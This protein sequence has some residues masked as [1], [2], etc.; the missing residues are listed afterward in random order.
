MLGWLATA[1]AIAHS[2]V[3]PARR[4]VWR[5]PAAL[6]LAHQEVSFRTA[7]GLVLRGWFV[8][9]G[10]AVEKSRG[11]VMLCHGYPGNRADMLPFA[12]FLHRAG[13]STL[14]FDFRALGQSGGGFSSVGHHE[15]RDALAATSYLRQRPDTRRLPLGV[16]GVSMGGAVALQAAAR[17]QT[18]GAVVAD[19]PYASLDR[20]VA[21]RFRRFGG[22]W[23]DVLG[24]PARWFGERMIGVDVSTVSPLRQ[25]AGISPRPLLLICGSADTTILP[26]DSALLFAA[27]RRPKALW[28][29]QGAGHVGAYSANENRYE[30]KVAAFFDGALKAKTGS[31]Q[32]KNKPAT[33]APTIELSSKSFPALT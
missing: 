8:P 20:A 30:E 24:V 18:I 29:V 13:W 7:D 15:V 19:S 2:F 33:K 5:T 10:K 6:G 21:Q 3:H 26:R 27:A 14:S 12:R 32:N 1:Y 22:R 4:A 17:T 11:V 31:G 16:L 28:R 9:A 23:G 25:V